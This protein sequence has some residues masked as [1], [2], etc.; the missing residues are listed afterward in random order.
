MPTLFRRVRPAP[1]PVTL[2][3]RL[4]FDVLESRD[5]PSAWD[6]PL[7]AVFE[8]TPPQP[9][10]A[11]D[12]GGGMAANAA[13]RIVDFDAK[14][15]G[16]GMYRFIGRV[17]DESP[18]GLAVVFAGVPTVEGVEVFTG[19]DGSFS[20]TI[21][22]QTDGT[23]TGMVSVLTMDNLGQMSNEPFVCVDPRG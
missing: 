5:C 18:A 21:Q 1:R 3:P 20:L 14:S 2:R 22:L 10:F 11:E 7:P 8:P 16:G 17:V 6:V 15:L 23:D 12:D 9:P 13:P 4:G 19:S